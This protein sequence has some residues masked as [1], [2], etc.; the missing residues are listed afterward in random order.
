MDTRKPGAGVN[1]PPGYEENDV[2][3][4]E[5][6]STCLPQQRGTLSSVLEGE[7]KRTQGVD[8]IT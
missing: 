5:G 8:D 4:P 3:H 6:P 1:V 2:M 7:W